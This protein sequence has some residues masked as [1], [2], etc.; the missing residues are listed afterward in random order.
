[1]KYKEYTSVIEEQVN[2]LQEAQRAIKVEPD[3]MNADR[4]CEIARTI[5]ALCNDHIRYT[6]YESKKASELR[7]GYG[8]TPE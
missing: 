3:G 8:G 6:E 1:M 7:T 2:A 4:C 5:S